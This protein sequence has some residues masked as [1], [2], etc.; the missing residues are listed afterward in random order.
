MLRCWVCGYFPSGQAHLMLFTH[1]WCCSYKGLFTSGMGTWEIQP[2]PALL[3]QSLWTHSSPVNW[4]RVI[5]WPSVSFGT[6]CRCHDI[7]G[8]TDAPCGASSAPPVLKPPWYPHCMKCLTWWWWQRFIGESLCLIL[9]TYF[10]VKA[11]IT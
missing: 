6:P 3:P 10:M 9:K 1:L 11:A 8:T 2:H 5:H 7:S 4:E